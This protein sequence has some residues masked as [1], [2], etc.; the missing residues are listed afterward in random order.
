MI[1]GMSIKLFD[2]RTTYCFSMLRIY[3]IRECGSV[4]LQFKIRH[5]S[6]PTAHGP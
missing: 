1:E 4:S 3:V 6:I 5:L 2:E